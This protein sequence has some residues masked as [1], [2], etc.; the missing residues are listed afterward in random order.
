VVEGI[1]ASQID[2]SWGQASPIS[3]ALFP[4]GWEEKGPF[5]DSDSAFRCEGDFNGD[6]RRD[7]AIAGVF[8]SRRGTPGGFLLILTEN[9]NRHWAVAFLQRLE[10]KHNFSS[11][12]CE[13]HHVNWFFCLACDDYVHVKWDGKRYRLVQPP[14][15]GAS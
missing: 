6:G 14:A 10:A 2:P 4:P 3:R 11:V 5:I 8:L 1:K 7:L 15:P 9:A 13:A 12:S